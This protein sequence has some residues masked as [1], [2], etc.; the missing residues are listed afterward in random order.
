MH[1]KCDGP[2]EPAIAFDS[3]AIPWPGR[4]VDPE[5]FPLHIKAITSRP[6][7]LLPLR[8]LLLPSLRNPLQNV[9]P[10]LIQLQ[11]RDDAFRGVDA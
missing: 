11:L 9:F 10:V 2:L 4:S 6:L 8:L 1:C 7:L 5:R 3:K